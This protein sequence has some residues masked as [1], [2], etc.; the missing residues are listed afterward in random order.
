MATGP[1]FINLAELASARVGGRAIATND[2]F[3]AP[4]S[5]LIKAEPAVWIADKYTSRGKWMDG[6]E[7][8]RGRIPGHDWCIVQLG[9]RG[10]V[11]GVDVDTS[12]FTG[13]FPSHCSIEAVDM[14][15]AP[16][17]AQH[18]VDGPPWTT[19]LGKTAL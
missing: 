12:F 8:R 6:W 18:A 2:D 13:N 14:S 16:A 1:E 17:A 10:V 7:A 11:H 19:I 5:N 9:M 3:F 4:K 15:S